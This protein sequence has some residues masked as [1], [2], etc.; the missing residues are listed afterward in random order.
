MKNDDP[1]STER[2]PPPVTE[3]LRSEHEQIDRLIDQLART[4]TPEQKQYVMDEIERRFTG[5]NE[6]EHRV[7]SSALASED[8]HLEEV[9]RRAIEDDEQTR[10]A[11]REIAHMFPWARNYDQEVERVVE[12]LR[13]HVRIEEH[14]AS[15]RTG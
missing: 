11:L 1:H 2:W 10:G 8:P 3:A 13:G 7:I 12:R 6:L 5:H 14:G 15:P 4:G 9:A